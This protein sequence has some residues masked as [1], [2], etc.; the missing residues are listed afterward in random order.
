MRESG[1]RHRKGRQSGR[2]IATYSR[3]DPR[4]CAQN[5][6][7]RGLTP[8]PGENLPWSRRV[9]WPVPDA[10]TGT[11]ITAVAVSLWPD[12]LVAVRMTVYVP[13]AA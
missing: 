5:E 4:G 1:G 6:P 13:A 8:R 7:G 12:A 3:S 10:V 9:Y 11:V 2:I